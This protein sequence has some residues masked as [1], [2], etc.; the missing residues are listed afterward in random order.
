MIKMISWNCR[1]LGS[2]HKI[3]LIDDLIKAGNPQVFMLQETRRKD[4]DILNEICYILRSCKGVVVNAR[5]A[6]GGVYTL[7]NPNFFA[8][9]SRQSTTH[10]IKTSLLHIQT[11]KTLTFINVFIPTLYQEKW[12]VGI[13][14][15]IYRILFTPK[16]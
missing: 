15:K 2:Q 9:Q 12:S 13:P 5:G 10:W 1:G 14:S 6:L 16:I 7:W 3:S 8:L 4:I 11:G